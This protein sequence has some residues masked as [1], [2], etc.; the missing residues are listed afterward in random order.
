MDRLPEY[1]LHHPLLL[2]LAVISFLAVL[3]YELRV[4]GQTAGALSPQD[5]VRMMN[6][7]ATLL[8]VRSAEAF[9]A[10][11]IRGAR[12][13]PAE[14]W[15]EAGESL[16]RLKER[17]IVVYCERGTSAAAAM[18]RLSAQGFSKV[19]NLRGG[20]SAWQAQNLPLARE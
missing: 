16:K 1:G 9:A 12:N 3:V 19:F 6:Q 10:G 4:R 20:I 15:G 2:A 8:D 14:Q 7:G 18:R 13:L 5:T 11:H 17:A